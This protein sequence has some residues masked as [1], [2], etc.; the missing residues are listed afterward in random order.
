MEGTR[1]HPDNEA[2]RLA[3]LMDL[4]RIGLLQ[5][6]GLGSALRRATELVARTVGAA[7]AGVWTFTPAR[8]AIICKDAYDAAADRH[9]AGAELLRDDHRP[10]FDAIASDDVI[11][12]ADALADPRTACLAER[13]LRPL[14]VGAL[15]DTPIRA[16]GA[17]YG[18]L[19]LEHVG[20]TRAWTDA[21]RAFAVAV[22]DLISLV[23][24]QDARTQ[25]ETRLRAIIESEPECVTVVSPDGNL[26]D[27]N[28]AGLAMVEADELASVRGRPIAP[29]IHADD[30]DAFF[31]LHRRCVDGGSGRLQ[32]RFLG[33]KGTERWMDAHAAPLRG[34][35]GSIE[36]VLSVTRDITE[37]R[38]A[39]A[40][41]IEQQQRSRMILETMG[42]GIHGL[43]AQGRVLFDNPAA[44]AM[45]GQ[46][47]DE[48]RGR[49]SHE[50]IHHHRADG[51]LYP[52]EE[53][54]I[55]R[56]LRDG[57]TRRVDGEVFFR[58]DGSSFPVEYVCA[59]M[60]RA[61]GSIAGAVVTFRDVSDRLRAER[62]RQAETE[63][64][65]L[66][67]AG[68]GL[69]EVLER[70]ALAIEEALAEARV[71]VFL[72]DEEGMRFRHGAAPRLSAFSEAVAGT[73]IG[74]EVGTA[75]AAIH[76]R[77]Q[78]I[79]TDIESDPL[80]SGFRELARAHGLRACWS[81]P[82][83]DAAGRPIA[84]LAVHYDSPRA[85]G[86]EDLGIVDR[87]A[88][89]VSLA[90][91]RIRSIE[92]L[93]AS[94]ATF[95]EAFRDAATGIVV[96]APDGKIQEVNEAFARIVGYTREE[97]R[98]G[99]LQTLTPPDDLP[100]TRELREELLSGRRQ[101][102]VRQK[103]Y[104]TKQGGMV[105]VRNSVSMRRD[106]S[107]RP[108]SAIVVSEDITRQ[109]MA[110][111]ELRH[112][113]ALL[114]MASR[115]GQLGGWEVRLPGYETTWSDQ[116]S[117]IHDL[118]PRQVPTVEA[119]FRFY[120]PEHR[121]LIRNAFLVCAVDGSPWDLELELVTATGRR[122]WVR[123]IGQAV[124]DENGR[125]V[126]VQG[127]LQDISERKQ[128]EARLRESESRFQAVAS[129]T[130][131][132]IWD[133]DL[134]TD[135]VW[136]SE[137]VETAF[138]WSADELEPDASSR[139]GRIHPDDRERVVAGLRHAIEHREASWAD[140]YRFL[141]RDGSVLEIEDRGMMIFGPDGTPSRLVGGMT[142]IT[143]RKRFQRDLRER[144]KELR[145]LYR[146]LELTTADTRSV[147]AICADIVAILPASL[148][149]D[150]HA[151]GRI[152]INGTSYYST[153]WQPPVQ[154]LTSPIRS[155]GN[156]IGV[157][158]IGY[159]ERMPDE[160]G[161]GS[162]FLSED[163]A[164]IDAVATHVGRMLHDRRV[165][166]TLRQAD[167]L[168]AV[169]QLTGGIAHDF[170][171][172]LTVILGNTELLAQKLMDDPPAQSLALIAQDAA[173][174]AAELTRRLLAFSRR[175][176]LAPRATD[177][178]ALLRGMQ[179]LLRRTL[180][181]HIQVRLVHAE[182]LW[183]ALID[184]PQLE[185]AILNLCINAR[186]AMPEGGVLTIESA[187]ANLDRSYAELD[188]ELE[189]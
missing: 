73:A 4:M 7:R 136:W 87:A 114:Q 26:L 161:L 20:G 9:E 55:F 82:A 88:R 129:V 45:L 123:S 74:P 178:I 31:D 46:T 128:A 145:C 159:R 173:E 21:D 57:V 70:I 160:P 40:E 81:T 112:S 115:I 176:A 107:G 89:L 6:G 97:L 13:Y 124:R 52:V 146:V 111:R 131:D 153:D 180:G 184:P 36:A 137:D 93:R 105:W 76:H 108:L 162:P 24:V 157:V 134:R 17:L 32:F 106:A 102:Y 62:L 144:I 1:N 143:A 34:P 104:R 185:S 149:H 63:I 10:Y 179:G 65:D 42:E 117:A 120:V 167:R 172:L 33:L 188:A 66:I 37:H 147:E 56:S 92:A 90:V 77:R 15:L 163:R 72:V 80:W 110:E 174:N 99:D 79:S 12:A 152:T 60:V 125:I 186:D 22:A 59:P 84:V 101:S 39:E 118:P 141:H 2:E 113:Q 48:T 132:V 5:P 50:L 94:E 168:R 23:H 43:D 69:S 183:H 91:Q 135:R 67:S 100:Y 68:A 171:N 187:N 28:P 103:R 95:R 122:I 164:L 189:L 53:C 8:D 119:S 96:A 154:A 109:T 25:S 126:A 165:G 138:G 169:G 133:W 29:L 16:E 177:V 83:L 86:L 140:E 175:Q 58:K 41:L 19:C 150:Q 44:L 51:S 3:A 14:G 71:A 121:D 127:A 11:V 54:P 182:S 49:H 47:A 130:A 78:V 158:E 181:E 18:V 170:N 30:R 64:F 98:G 27:M 61:D 139:T 38:S 155:E 156:E 85:P 35:D 151:V 142:D 148:L 116:V 166:E 75:G